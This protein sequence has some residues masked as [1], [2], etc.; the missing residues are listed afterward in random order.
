MRWSIVFFSILFAVPIVAQANGTMRVQQSDGSVQLYDVTMAVSGRQLLITTAN[1]KGTLI[2]DEAAC[3]V[4]ARVMTCIP[5]RVRLRQN[6]TVPLDFERGTVYFNKTNET[7]QLKY[8]S[9]QIPPNGVLG[10][11]KSPK[12]TYVTWSGTLDSNPK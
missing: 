3:T 9:T 2:V 11:M 6:G 12:G 7:Q 5:E 1:K 4:D 10:S 8:S